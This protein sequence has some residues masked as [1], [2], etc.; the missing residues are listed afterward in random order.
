MTSATR[1][2]RRRAALLPAAVGRDDSSTARSRSRSSVAESFELARYA[3]SLVE[4]E[5]APDAHATD[6]DAQLRTPSSRRRLST[7]DRPRGDADRPMQ[8]PLIGTKPNTAMPSSTTTRW[9]CT[10]RR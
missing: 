9:K 8:P 1:T 5:Y 4:V 7:A 3:A 2:K 6:L 10:R